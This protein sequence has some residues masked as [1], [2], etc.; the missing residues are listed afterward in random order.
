MAEEARRRSGALRTPWRILLVPRL[1]FDRRHEGN[2]DVVRGGADCGQSYGVEAP[3][4]GALNRAYSRRLM[5]PSFG[6][7]R[8]WSG[9]RC[10][11]WR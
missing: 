6:G 2:E 7:M 3:G 1:D 9:E 8:G 5:R 4:G 10:A 11:M